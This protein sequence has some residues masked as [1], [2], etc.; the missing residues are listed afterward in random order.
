MQ[1]HVLKSFRFTHDNGS[2]QDFAPGVHDV[3]EGVAAHWF[4]Q[5]HIKPAAP[6]APVTPQE[7]VAPTKAP[8]KSR[9]AATAVEPTEGDAADSGAAETGD[10]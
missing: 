2:T 7:P 4:V 3:P 9:K 8:R 10:A 1:I 5:A 6:Q